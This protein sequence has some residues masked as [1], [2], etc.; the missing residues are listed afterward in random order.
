M[1]RTYMGVYHDSG[2]E[3]RMVWCTYI[4][5]A[6]RMRD[7]M[8]WLTGGAHGLAG[9]RESGRLRAGAN[10]TGRMGEG[11]LLFVFLGRERGE[12]RGGEGERSGGRGL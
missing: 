1:Y 11:F 2:R 6:L 12:R 3:G 8:G 10:G 4:R 7:E 9:G 5:G